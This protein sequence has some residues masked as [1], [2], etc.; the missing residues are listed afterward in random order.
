MLLKKYTIILVILFLSPIIYSQEIYHGDY[1]NK[2][3]S[4]KN[5]NE[6]KL[7]RTFIQLT[8][9]DDNTYC[10]EEQIYFKN[11]LNEESIVN[12]FKSKGTW[13]KDGKNLTIT[14][15]GYSNVSNF[16]ISCNNKKMFLIEKNSKL[17]RRIKYKKATKSIDIHC[18]SSP[19]QN[20]PDDMDMP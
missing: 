3:N 14:S 7:Y 10:I 11:K 13:K 4:F 6:P 2:Y 1:S 9:Y 18:K 5:I 16:R 12:C 20:D 8:L 15:D 19:I 17:N